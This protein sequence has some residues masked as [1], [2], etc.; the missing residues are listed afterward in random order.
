M[1]SNFQSS[2][3]FLCRSRS[4]LGI[5]KVR[6]KNLC[7]SESQNISLDPLTPVAAVD[8][9]DMCNKGDRMLK[10]YFL[11]LQK[12]RSPPQPSMR[13]GAD[14]RTLTEETLYISAL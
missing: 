6:P 10:K 2:K 5:S 7:P 11:G 12:R 3:G 13:Q 8:S 4:N 9:Q 14:I 1:L